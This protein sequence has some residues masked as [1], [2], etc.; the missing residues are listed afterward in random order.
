VRRAIEASAGHRGP[1]DRDW[2]CEPLPALIDHIVTVYHAW[3]REEMPRLEQMAGR[4]ARVHGA[5]APRLLGR[6]E[7]I[8]GELSADLREHMLKEERVLFPAICAL[9]AGHAPALPVALD[10]PIR[11]MMREHDAAGDL[12]A[13]LRRITDGYTPPEW[14]CATSRALYATLEELERDMHVHVHLENNILFPAALRLPALAV[15]H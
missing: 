4:V 8:V 14:G 10:A 1:F 2:T 6:L 5:K 3:L 9:D 13:E 12:L 7:A 15:T 11:V